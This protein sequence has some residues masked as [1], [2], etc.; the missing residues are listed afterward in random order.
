MFLLRWVWFL[1][2]SLSTALAGFACIYSAL[3]DKRVLAG[4]GQ[5][6]V[7]PASNGQD[8][9]EEGEGTKETTSREGQSEAKSEEKTEEPE[10]T[11]DIS[12]V[13]SDGRDEEEN[14]DNFVVVHA[15]N[16]RNGD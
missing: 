5:R 3:Q 7:L 16:E 13:K 6:E 15:E 4:G 12:Q 11:E 2:L 1:A 14:A 10:Q 8:E 9:K